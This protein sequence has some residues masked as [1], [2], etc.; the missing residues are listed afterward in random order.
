MLRLKDEQ[1][2]LIFRFN[3]SFTVLFD[4]VDAN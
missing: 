1:K 3:Y 4:S 2:A